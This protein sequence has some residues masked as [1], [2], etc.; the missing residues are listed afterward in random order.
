ME[1]ETQLKRAMIEAAD[2]V[3]LVASEAKFP[4]TGSLRV[5]SLAQIDTL[6][7][8]S[9]ADPQTLELC[10]EAGGKVYLA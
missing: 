3:V 8:T 2:Q 10:R 4:G 1:I 5:C 9:G 6:I 7:T